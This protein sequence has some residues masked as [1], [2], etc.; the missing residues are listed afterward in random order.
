M[1]VVVMANPTFAQEQRDQATRD[2]SAAKEELRLALKG[3]LDSA[4]GH[5][6]KSRI[7][8]TWANECRLHVEIDEAGKD[9]RVLIR[10]DAV[11]EWT[12]RGK[13]G[14]LYVITNKKLR[15]RW[16][17]GDNGARIYNYNVQEFC[18]PDDHNTSLDALENAFNK[19]AAAC[20]IM[21]IE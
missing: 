14:V 13:T 11:P 18:F 15:S 19:I 5:K 6:Y 4:A 20:R 16:F 3:Y 12:R 17:Y 21:R 7:T 1:F 8:L 2:L 10:G 9:S